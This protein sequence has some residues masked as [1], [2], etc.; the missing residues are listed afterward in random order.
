M[1]EYHGWVALWMT[2]DGEG[3]LRAPPV[4]DPVADY[5]AALDWYN[6][7]C[8]LRWFNRHRFVHFGGYTNRPRTVPEE[9]MALLRL[10][11]RE[12]PASYGLV[13]TQDDEDPVAYNEWRVWVLARG[14]I[15]METDPFLSPRN[16]TTSD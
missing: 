11:A 9:M 2:T 10:I 14:Q 15:R 7:F 8:D 16:P 3:E 6:G 4:P 13:Y 12:A 5:I 1:Y